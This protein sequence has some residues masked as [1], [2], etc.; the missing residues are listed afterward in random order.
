MPDIYFWSCM[1][2]LSL[3]TIFTRSFFLTIGANLKLSPKIRNLIQ[4]APTGALIAIVIPELFFEKDIVT[5]S[6]QFA[7]HSA[8]IYASIATI[9]SYYLSKSMLLSLSIGMLILTLVT[10]YLS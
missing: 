4:Y 5:K 7:M 3:V 1:I 9:V 6:Y 2:T 10:N 8:Q